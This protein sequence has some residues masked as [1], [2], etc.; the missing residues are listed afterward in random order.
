[1][2]SFV[3]AGAVPDGLG[4]GVAEPRWPFPTRDPGKSAQLTAA[5]GAENVRQHWIGP[6]TNL[7]F[8]H[9]RGVAERVD[10]AFAECR[11]DFRRLG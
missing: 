3:K 9:S 7:D 1:M 8:G 10:D 4:D 11:L 2:G 5:P 6:R